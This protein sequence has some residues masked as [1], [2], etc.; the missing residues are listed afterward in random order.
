MN[1]P[2]LLIAAAHKSSGKTTL[3]IGLARALAD[4]GL[5]V[6]AF[7][8][9]PDYIDPMWLARASGRPCFNLD[10]HL[11]HHAEIAGL[12][13]RYSA[14]ADISLIEANLGLHDGMAL[15]GSN[16]NAALARQLGCPVVLV[17]DARGMTRSIAALILGYQAFDKAVRIGGVIL[18][19]VSGERHE[20]GLRAAIAHYTDVP[21]LGAVRRDPRLTMT[22][23]HLGLTPTS[24]VSDVEQ[25]LRE[26]A[27]LV[28]AQVDLAAVRA[29]ATSA[30]ALPWVPALPSAHSRHPT[31]PQPPLRIAIARD[32][33][34][35]FYY[36][37]DLTALAAAG[38]TLVP[39][40]TLRDAQLPPVDGLFIGGGFPESFLPQLQANGALRAA[41]RLA[42]EQGMPTYAECGGLMYLAR[43]IRHKD[44]TMQMV[45]A[46]PAD[47]VMHERPVGRGYV[48]LSET[49]F[50]PWPMAGFADAAGAADA[51]CAHAGDGAPKAPCLA[52]EFHHSALCNI[53]TTVR[54]A[55]AVQRGHGIDG[56]HDGIVI[57]NMLA[58]YAHQRG[59]GGNCWPERF[60]GFVRRIAVQRAAVGK[61]PPAQ[62][63]AHSYP[64]YPQ[65][66]VT[67]CLV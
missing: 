24:E 45:G 32:E 47:V 39:I 63:L 4:Q 26:I 15:D 29:L 5:A 61:S 7:K 31:P 51:L 59:S 8:K 48:R 14:L 18:N 35:G 66:G 16:S 40:D 33:A 46:V 53:D 67:P 27:A 55:Y 9:G 3:S 44:Q 30:S 37:D 20:A 28:A 65:P 12:F 11:M 17:L 13:A 10:I 58:A 56:L 41:I 23:R 42:I 1:C 43:T 57:H 49:G 50:H 54:Y 38:A 19:Q 60:V 52:H 2:R 62:F 36:P 21:V 22:E 6:Q 64:Q 25:R 34:F